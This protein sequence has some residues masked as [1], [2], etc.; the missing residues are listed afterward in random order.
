MGIWYWDVRLVSLKIDCRR[1]E[2]LL[3]ILPKFVRLPLQPTW[4]RWRLSAYRSKQQFNTFQKVLFLTVCNWTAKGFATARRLRMQKMATTIRLVWLSRLSRFVMT[5]IFN[6]FNITCTGG[7]TYNRASSLIPLSWYHGIILYR[8][9]I[10]IL[11]HIYRDNTML[12]ISLIST[13]NDKPSHINKTIRMSTYST[14]LFF[15]FVFFNCAFDPLYSCRVA[16]DF[17][18]CLH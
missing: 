8:Y 13:I 12:L 3:A 10:T 9:H 5:C 7:N 15:L 17:V 6:I 14:S 16:L 18:V 2:A 1:V 11:I 4:L